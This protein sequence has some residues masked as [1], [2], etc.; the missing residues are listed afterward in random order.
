M[1]VLCDSDKDEA[2]SDTQTQEAILN[3]ILSARYADF[4]SQ[5]V[6]DQDNISARQAH[7]L[8]LLKSP[9]PLFHWRFSGGGSSVKYFK[10]KATVSVN[11][12]GRFYSVMYISYWCFGKVLLMELIHSC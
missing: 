8:R 10:V 4:D 5:I 3:T 7:A 6:R 9:T 11:L 12:F 1:T 2:D